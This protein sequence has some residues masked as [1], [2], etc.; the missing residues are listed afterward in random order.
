[1]GSPP[2]LRHSS[3]VVWRVDDR[4]SSLTRQVTRMLTAAKAGLTFGQLID[5]LAVAWRYT[6]RWVPGIAELAGSVINPG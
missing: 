6:E 3:Q 2:R 1:M 5:D 4:S